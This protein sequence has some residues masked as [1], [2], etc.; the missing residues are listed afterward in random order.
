MFYRI[1]YYKSI[2][3]LH[4]IDL[5]YCIQ[6]GFRWS[7]VYEHDHDQN[8][9]IHLTVAHLRARKSQASPNDVCF[10]RQLQSQDRKAHGMLKYSKS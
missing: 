6:N 5:A 9:D 4:C 1:F 8:E 2:F 7:K 3:I 10:E